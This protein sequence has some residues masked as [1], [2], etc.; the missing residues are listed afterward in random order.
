MT[1]RVDVTLISPSTYFNFTPLLA[2]CAVGTLEY[3]TAI[4]PVSSLA[5]L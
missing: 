5:D 4:E 2:S 1:V 3:R